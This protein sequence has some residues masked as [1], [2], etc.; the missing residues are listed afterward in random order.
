[1]CAAS[2]SSQTE[3]LRPK[4]SGQ[5]HWSVSGHQQTSAHARVMSAKADINRSGVEVCFG[6]L[7]DHAPQ[8][9][10]RVVQDRFGL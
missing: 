9:V 4:E 6:P 5:V 3:L 2:Q 8:Q 10:R 7:P 1:M